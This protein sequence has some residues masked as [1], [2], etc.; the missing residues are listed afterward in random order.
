MQEAFSG[1]T[2]SHVPQKGTPLFR[3]CSQQNK[4]GT[5]KHFLQAVWLLAWL[6][7]SMKVEGLWEV[8]HG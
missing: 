1:Q 4:Q 3:S 2:L 7:V 6:A 5:H 8:M